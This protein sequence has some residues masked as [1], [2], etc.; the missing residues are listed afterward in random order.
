MSTI[1]R[2]DLNRDPTSIEIADRMKI[3]VKKVERLAKEV[4]PDIFAIPTLGE[5]GFDVNP[6]EETSS[7]HREVVEMLPYD[8]TL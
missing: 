5:G 3:S 6:F 1:Y 7:V 8:L 4:R 2:E